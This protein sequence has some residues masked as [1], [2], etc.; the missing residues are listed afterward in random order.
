MGSARGE[1]ISYVFGL[2]LIAG[3][4]FFPHNYTKQDQ[5]VGEAMLTFMTNFAKTANPNLPHNIES[6]D[7]G[8]AREKTR[9]RGLIWEQYETNNQQYLMIG[10]GL[11][12]RFTYILNILLYFLLL[13]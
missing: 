2:P 6:V 8:N 10:K 13:L 5:S 7:Y 3:G 11:N 12:F 4:R 1:D 9:F